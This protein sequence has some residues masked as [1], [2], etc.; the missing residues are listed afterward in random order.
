ME[1]SFCEKKATYYAYWAKECPRVV[2]HACDNHF[3][4]MD[5]AGRSNGQQLSY[6]HPNLAIDNS[7][8][9]TIVEFPRKEKVA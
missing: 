9:S 8:Y 6:H 1:C 3:D 5:R 7:R 4:E 2:V